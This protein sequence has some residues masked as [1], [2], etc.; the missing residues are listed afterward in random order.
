VLSLL[1]TV[2]AAQRTNANIFLGETADELQFPCMNPAGCTL[3]RKLHSAAVSAPSHILFRARD[4][5]AHKHRRC[6]SDGPCFPLPPSM[7]AATSTTSAH[8][9]DGTQLGR[10]APVGHQV[11]ARSSANTYFPTLLR[12]TVR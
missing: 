5:G 10:R 11:A 2:A 4:R 3:V 7:R 8:R 12:L 1:Q 9:R 6:Q